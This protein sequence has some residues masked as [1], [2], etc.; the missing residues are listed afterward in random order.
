MA[1]ETLRYQVLNEIGRIQLRKYDAY[2]VASVKTV[3]DSYTSAANRAFRLLADYIFGNNTVK[4]KIQMTAPVANQKVASEQIA[5]TAS[6]STKKAE[7]MSYE[8]SFIMP[9]AYSMETLPKPNNKAVKIKQIPAHN[10]AVIMF[11]GYT[12]EGKIEKKERELKD[13]ARQN[14]IKIQGELIVLRYDPPW[15]P[16]F[17]RRNEISIKVA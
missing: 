9:S 8:V 1:V 10:A 3:G 13:W 2:I 6:V 15:K 12:T 16:G 7:G 11:S 5:M 17:L 14:N 4:S